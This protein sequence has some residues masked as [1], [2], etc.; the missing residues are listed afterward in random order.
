MAP[1]AYLNWHCSLLLL[2]ISVWETLYDYSNQQ[3]HWDFSYF[4]KNLIEKLFSRFLQ[5]SLHPWSPTD[6]V[7]NWQLVSNFSYFK[8][9]FDEFSSA[10]FIWMLPE[11]LSRLSQSNSSYFYLASCFALAIS[12][13][14]GK[15]SMFCN[16]QMNKFHKTDY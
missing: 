11:L 5:Y 10:L 2:G 6:F 16:F 3:P 13:I 1:R 9:I 15:F 12:M 8:T 14:S 7:R 4:N